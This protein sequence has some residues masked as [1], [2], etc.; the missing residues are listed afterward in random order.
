M[1][2]AILIIT[3]TRQSTQIAVASCNPTN[4]TVAG[5]GKRG[6][7]IKANRRE[8][9]LYVPW[10]HKIYEFE[11]ANSIALIS[12]GPRAYSGMLALVGSGRKREK[13][14]ER[15]TG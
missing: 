1:W 7:E 12:P 8:I 4:K 5:A 3:S 2:P 10:L 14:I 11:Y 9:I 15:G 13:E 6:R